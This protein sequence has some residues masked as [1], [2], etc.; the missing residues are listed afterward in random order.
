M[1]SSSFIPKIILLGIPIGAVPQARL[2]GFLGN[3]LAA[4][5]DFLMGKL[6]RL[7]LISIFY[8]VRDLLRIFLRGSYELSGNLV[9]VQK[10]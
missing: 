2:F 3:S 1:K 5:L 7:I 9:R 8:G 10:V 6:V 4:K